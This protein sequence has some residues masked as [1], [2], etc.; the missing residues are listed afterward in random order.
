MILI[1]IMKKIDF[2]QIYKMGC[3]HHFESF[4]SLK[5]INKKTLNIIKEYLKTEEKEFRWNIN[6][7]LNDENYFS[8]NGIWYK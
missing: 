6:E 8:E 5:K 2:Q 3:G 1:Y 7:Y 4:Y